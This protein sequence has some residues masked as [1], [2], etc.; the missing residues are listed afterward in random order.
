MDLGCWDRVSR[1]RQ[2]SDRR[3][4]RHFRDTVGLQAGRRGQSLWRDDRS[5]LR[6]AALVSAMSRIGWVDRTLAAAALTG[7]ALVATSALA[8]APGNFSTLTASSAATLNGDVL[9]C[10]GRPWIDVRCPSLAGGAVGNGDHDDTE[11]IQAAVA[12]GVLNNWPVHLSPGTY[13]VTAG[14]TID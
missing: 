7:T 1:R 5:G 10:S 3:Q 11:A 9:I 12:A 13:K 4:R 8:Q 2:H 6:G 14:L